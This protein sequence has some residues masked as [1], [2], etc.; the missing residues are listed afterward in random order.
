MNNLFKI[1]NIGACIVLCNYLD[2][3]VA[4]YENGDVDNILL[5][6]DCIATL[7]MLGDVSWLHYSKRMDKAEKIND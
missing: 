2:G 7:K 4:D 1:K 5:I 6:E 3:A